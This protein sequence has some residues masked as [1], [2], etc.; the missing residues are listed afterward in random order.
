MQVKLLEFLQDSTYT[1]VGGTKRIKMDTRVIAATN[2]DLQKMCEDNTFRSDL[3][4]R[5]N[6]MPLK[7]PPLRQRTDD[8]EIL[9]KH[10]MTICNSKYNEYKVYEEGAFEFLKTYEWP[11]NVRELE[12]VVERAFI[13]SDNNVITIDKLREAIFGSKEASIKSPIICSSIIPLKEAKNEVERQI[14]MKACERYDTTY[15]IADALE[16]DQSTVVKLLKKHR[17][18]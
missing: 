13:I 14:L 17:K 16:I 1:K 4:Y 18:T 7:I 5:L 12:H 10:F 3:Y 15:K 9:A 11:G 2:R 6:V 8:I